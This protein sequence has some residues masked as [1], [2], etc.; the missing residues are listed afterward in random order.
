MAGVLSVQM[1]LGDLPAFASLPPPSHKTVSVSRPSAVPSST[2]VLPATSDLR[3]LLAGAGSFTG[4]VPSGS[5]APLLIHIQDIHG[6]ARAQRN[7]ETALER[8]LS[9]GRPGGILLEG[10][11]GELD[12]NAFRGSPDPEGAAL[13]IEK[14]LGDHRLSG[15]AAALLRSTNVVPTVR[16]LEDLRVYRANLAAVPAALAAAPRAAAGLRPL[17]ERIDELKKK[18]YNEQLF[19]TDLAVTRYEDG[20]MPLVSLLTLLLHRGAPLDAAMA[21]ILKVQTLEQMYD[22]ADV[23]SEI[24]GL[25]GRLRGRLTSTESAALFDAAFRFQKGGLRLEEFVE[26]LGRLCDAHAIDIA[27]YPHLR[28]HLE[29]ALLVQSVSPDRLYA[30]VERLR[31]AVLTPLAHTDTE[32]DL[33]NLDR[34][35]RLLAKLSRLALSPNEWAELRS[36]LPASDDAEVSG[37]TRE[38]DGTLAALEAAKN[39][40]RYAEKRNVD[41]AAAIQSLSSAID[42][43]PMVVVAGGYHGDAIARAAA[44]NGRRYV[45]F[46]PSTGDLRG[47][48]ASAP[49]RELTRPG[50]AWDAVVEARSQTLAPAPAP[51]SALARLAATV[52]ARGTMSNRSESVQWGRDALGR[53]AL[54][55]DSVKVKRSKAGAVARVTVSR[56][57]IAT[58]LVVTFGPAGVTLVA[59][60]GFL[61][62]TV[63]R[64]RRALRRAYYSVVGVKIVDVSLHAGT[65]AWIRVIPRSPGHGINFYRVDGTAI[66]MSARRVPALLSHIRRNLRRLTGLENHGL[67]V[68]TVEHLL[69]AMKV[70]GIRDADV[71]VYGDELPILD[72][73]AQMFIDALEPLNNWSPPAPDF[74]LREPVVFRRDNRT[75]I[76]LLPLAEDET[77]SE[78]IFVGNYGTLQKD[79]L[80]FRITAD[81]RDMG[82][83]IAELGSHPTFAERPLAQLRPTHFNGAEPYKPGEVEDLNRANRKPRPNYVDV[84]DPAAWESADTRERLARHKVMDVLGDGYLLELTMNM[85]GKWR[86]IALGTGHRDT[87]EAMV[88]VASGYR[89]PVGYDRLVDINL[90]EL[91]AANKI[92]RGLHDDIVAAL[93][94]Y[95]DYDKD[96]VAA[97]NPQNVLPLAPDVLARLSDAFHW[98]RPPPREF[99]HALADIKEYFLRSNGSALVTVSEQ[100]ATQ[101]FVPEQIQTIDV[102]LWDPNVNEATFLVSFGRGGELVESRPKVAIVMS[103]IS[104]NEQFAQAVYSARRADEANEEQR[105]RAMGP[106]YR[107][108]T[109][110]DHAMESFPKL[111]PYKKDIIAKEWTG[112]QYARYSMVVTKADPSGMDA[113]AVFDA[114]WD[115]PDRSE[116]RHLNPTEQ[117][118]VA[119]SAAEM[120][121]NGFLQLFRDKPL[122]AAPITGHLIDNIDF[123]RDFVY[124]PMD[125]KAGLSMV[126]NL[127]N[128][129]V[130]QF[131]FHVFHMQ[132]TVV[133]QTAPRS[134]GKAPLARK[135]WQPFAHQTAALLDGVQAALEKQFGSA[136]GKAAAI[137]WFERYLEAIEYPDR[138]G[139]LN[140]K[141]ADVN[142]TWRYRHYSLFEDREMLLDSPENQVSGQAIQPILQARVRA[143]KAEV[144]RAEV[145]GAIRWIAKLFSRLT[146]LPMEVSIRLAPI[147]E[148]IFFAALGLKT[149]EVVLAH[150]PFANPWAVAVISAATAFVVWMLSHLSVLVT[151]GSERGWM[152]FLQIPARMQLKVLGLGGLVAAL[153]PLMQVG[154]GPVLVVAAFVAGIHFWANPAVI[155]EQRTGG[156]DPLLGRRHRIRR[157]LEGQA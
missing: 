98:A 6:H 131:L 57:G 128:V 112:D 107:P 86:I 111:G 151:K 62:H 154:G 81:P 4:G 77:N 19:L 56:G 15:A 153:P 157:N 11:V 53:M 7:I 148:G 83:L 85:T 10:L 50:D 31:P 88:M 141:G 139:P 100:V 114:F 124:D 134:H 127:R 103:R 156:A 65:R 123:E 39:F 51:V 27:S 18:I 60:Q 104:G 82:E 149:Q 132:M 150:N 16:G 95:K 143:L 96:L 55:L 29:H 17:V 14:L 144:A 44:R 125:K 145:S 28:L 97:G 64:A 45:S 121:T 110:S 33:L 129:S 87:A 130:E 93:A 74:R 92:S 49:L 116:R 101:K 43:R 105:R 36:P 79:P 52:I 59:V 30:A 66:S 13:A 69:L 118:E 22:S 146:S 58:T 37:L 120:M 38:I 3:T 40:Y 63:G 102:Q 25:M 140:N 1:V 72:G 21:A 76:M 42:A 119:A 147:T 26:T 136:A 84:S 73:S 99:E 115:H 80:E 138:L 106:G 9:R 126:R 71:R 46:T 23:G 47:W 68:G 20:R 67:S 34:R 152:S 94:P 155:L 108:R 75:A 41:F 2:P 91:L 133:Y 122:T 24:R 135:E 12:V 113:D 142:M 90:A 78:V 137:T 54:T 109:A 48:D 5:A 89:Y 32:R 117:T 70:R 35:T 61:A 8:L